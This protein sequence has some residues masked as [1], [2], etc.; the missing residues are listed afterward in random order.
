MCGSAHFPLFTP[1]KTAIRPSATV[2]QAL[3]HLFRVLTCHTS[4]EEE[5]KYSTQVEARPLRS[6]LITFVF[7]CIFFL[8][9]F[10]KLFVFFSG[11]NLSLVLLKM[12]A[13]NCNLC[14]TGCVCFSSLKEDLCI[15]L[16]TWASISIHFS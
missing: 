12:S 4:S 10:L 6:I 14:R 8:L 16:V 7:Y 13:K 9:F 11:L 15:I 2:C 1:V 3:K 5:M